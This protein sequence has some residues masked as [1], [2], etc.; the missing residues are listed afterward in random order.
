MDPRMLPCLH[1]FCLPCLVKMSEIQ[2]AKETLQCP[3]CEEKSP[4][5]DGAVHTLV[6]DLRKEYE[7]EVAQ[8]QSKFDSEAGI[9]CDRCLR[10]NTG[11]AIT[12][13]T[14]CCEFLCKAC[15]E[16]H[17]SW[18]KTQN[19]EILDINEQTSKK[20]NHGV[21]INLPHQ[22]MPCPI[23]TDEVLKVYCEQCEKLICRDCMEF[24]HKSHRD[25]CDRVEE[26]AAKEKEKLS[27]C[28]GD[29]QEAVAALE[30][31]I[32]VCNKTIQEVE[33]KKKEIDNAITRSL[34]EVREA[35]L[36]QNE[37]IRLSK[38][39]SL[40]IQVNELKKAKEE[41]S[42]TCD[43]ISAAQSHT[44][45]QLLSTKAVMVERATKLLCRYRSNGVEPVQKAMFLT[46]IVET[47]VVNHMITLG[48]LS[49]GSHATSSTCNAGYVPHAV[50][51]KE[52]VIKVVTRDEAGKPFGIGSERVDAKL[53]LIDSEDFP[54]RGS[55]TDHG[56]GSYSVSFTPQSPGEY[57]L[58]VTIA[59]V[60]VKGSP[61]RYIV[62]PPKTEPYSALSQ[63]NSISVSKYPYDVAVTEDGCLV[64][65]E[66]DSHTVSL[67]SMSG[68]QLHTFGTSGS[69]ASAD[70]QFYH[71]SA[72]AVCDD[73]MYVVDSH[74]HRVQ[75][76]NI[77]SRSFIS[78]FGKNGSGNGAFSYPRGICIDPEGQ[79][80]VADKGNN[81]IQVFQPDGTYISSIDCKYPWGLAFD[82]QGQ[83]HVASCDSNEIRVYSPERAFVG[84]Y[85]TGVVS[86]PAGI[87]IMSD[88]HIAI[89][90]HKSGGRV[91]I[92]SPDYA[93]LVASIQK[94]SNP[95]GIACDK[96]NTLWIADYS[97]Q[98]IVQYN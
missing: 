49:G 97:K 81:R 53:S 54:I 95:A 58:C 90:E 93:E 4:L 96:D 59:G 80:F 30:E 79:V 74:N 83:L 32:V 82:V 78:K 28:L 9:E 65:A 52:R 35:L 38:I 43:V 16:E 94:F 31:A 40:E 50:V 56:D 70:G 98:R 73:E 91:R 89:S 13:C 21:T 61:F 36:A 71:P 42:D 45:A 37:E 3:T 72:V 18:R 66:Y 22:P 2:G 87:A 85:G 17:H 5:K 69:S 15:K 29:S 46:K 41:L 6:K 75:K 8:F 64:V 24:K 62:S 51:G 77:T 7:V 60:H 84:S 67:Y 57:E 12:F 14:S 1:T 11:P 27:T 63:M 25:Q 86:S 88:G 26:V 20:G 33:S 76:F 92:Y 48:Q 23:H 39:T 68:K 34:N 44:P 55:T 10:K 19:H 47:A